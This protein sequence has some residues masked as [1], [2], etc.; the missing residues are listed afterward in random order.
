[1][2]PAKAVEGVR[3]TYLLGHCDPMDEKKEMVL[4]EQQWEELAPLSAA[5]PSGLFNNMDMEPTSGIGTVESVDDK[6]NMDPSA[7][8]TLDLGDLFPDLPDFLAYS[9]EEQPSL[10]AM[11][12][13]GACPSPLE[14]K[15]MMA[16]SGGLGR[17]EQLASTSSCASGSETS[18]YEDGLSPAE[19]DSTLEHFFNT[20]ADLEQYLEQP[21][22]ETGPTATVDAATV[23]SL[24]HDTTTE[25]G[26]S[27]P[28]LLTV[29]SNALVLSAVNAPKRALPQE[30]K[31][32]EGEEEEEA[33]SCPVPTKSKKICKRE[34]TRRVRSDEAYRQ[35]RIKN[36]QACKRARQNR[37]QREGGMQSTADGLEEENALLRAKIKELEEIAEFSRKALVDVL[38]VAK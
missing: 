37:K 19:V 8:S 9:E 17:R 24:I 22:E 33:A 34:S 28:D 15:V 31:R 12:E 7:T 26:S 25:N 4:V 32:E 14:T 38:V 35:R 3:G 5:Q 10:L 16:P 29:D 36:N 20:F 1:M 2:S 11:E 27:L 23:H 21:A 18:D 30:F 6:L 13:V